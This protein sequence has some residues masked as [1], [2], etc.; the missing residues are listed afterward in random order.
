MFRI[1]DH[2]ALRGG[3]R[4]VIRNQHCDD[5]N[6]SRQL[7]AAGLAARRA[8]PCCP[9]ARS[10]PPFFTSTS[11]AE[12]VYTGCTG[13]AQEGKGGS[14]QGGGQDGP[15]DPNECPSGYQAL[16]M[17]CNPRHRGFSVS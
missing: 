2:P 10:T 14:T 5:E 17:S 3:L 9:A 16:A 1:V 11:M 7:I 6:T 12:G 13:Q 8:M 4:K 15:S